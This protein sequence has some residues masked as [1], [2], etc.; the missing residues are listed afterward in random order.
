MELTERMGDAITLANALYYLGDVYREK[1]ICRSSHSMERCAAVCRQHGHVH[2]LS[3]ALTS[4]GLVR[5]HQGGHDEARAILLEATQVAVSARNVWA[6][7]YAMR[8]QADTLRLDGKYEEALHAYDRS[9][10]V[11]MSIEDR[12]SMGINLANMSLVS[13]LLDDY[14]ASAQHANRALEMFQ[15]IGNVPALSATTAGLCRLTGRQPVGGA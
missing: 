3:L 10:R 6:Q 5:Y 14:A 15:A 1:W 13:N 7:S 11:A 2:R 9:L 12:I 8:V 4:L